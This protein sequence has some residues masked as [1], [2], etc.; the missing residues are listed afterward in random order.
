MTRK[1]PAKPGRPK[2]TEPPEI[3]TESKNKGQFG[4]ENK[5]PRSQTSLYPAD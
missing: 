5:P 3:A 2:K 1:K 4:G